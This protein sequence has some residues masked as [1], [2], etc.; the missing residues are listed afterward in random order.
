[1]IF[2]HSPSTCVDIAS[3]EL[4]LL[5]TCEFWA[6]EKVVGQALDVGRLS[7]CEGEGTII[8]G[9]MVHSF[10]H[11]KS[12]IFSSRPQPSGIVLAIHVEVNVGQHR[13][14]SAS[15]SSNARDWYGFFY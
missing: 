13:V 12:A 6:R 5:P 1:M 14:S 2:T 7:A 11:A 10:A 9:K 4:S 3:S 15:L 8:K